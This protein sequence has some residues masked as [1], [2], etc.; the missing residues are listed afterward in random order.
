MKSSVNH[1]F[2]I[3]IIVS[4]SLLLNSV[5]TP[6][7]ATEISELDEI[8]MQVIG[9][10]SMGNIEI[11]QKINI[12]SPLAPTVTAHDSRNAELSARAQSKPGSR[13]LPNDKTD[14]HK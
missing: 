9:A 12:P 13:S 2:S 1:I 11:Q 8:T 7:F 5:T 10:E 3:S 14:V 4:A 6:C